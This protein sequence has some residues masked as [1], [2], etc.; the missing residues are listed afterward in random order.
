MA[1][2]L[3]VSDMHLEPAR[4]ETIDLFMAFLNGPAREADA[5]YLLGDIFEV[6]FG[7]DA[8]HPA[9]EPLL[10]AL[11][12]LD[13]DLYLQHGNRDFLMGRDLTERLGAELLPEATVVDLGGEPTLLLH[14]DSLCTDDTEHQA[15]RAMVLDPQW[16]AGFLALSV[17]ER[18]EQARQ[19]REQSRA[20]QSSKSDAIMDVNADA[21][22]AAFRDHGVRRIIHGHTHRPAVHE[23]TVDGTPARRL[24]LPQWHQ[25]G[26]YI[27]CDDDT[28]ELLPYPPGSDFPS[29]HAQY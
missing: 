1:T 29:H 11:A 3:L 26:G 24:V 21:V 13:A 10:D 5:L 19:A 23:T 22:A 25:S 2:T 28:C 18:A 4:P 9:Y 6:W 15:F 12:A 20:S 8:I 7:D 14:G 17:A 27:R 16:Q